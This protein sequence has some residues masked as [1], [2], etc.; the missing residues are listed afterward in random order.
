M[1]K[2]AFGI[3]ISLLLISLVVLFCIILIKLYIEKIKKYNAQIYENEINFQKT[4]NASIVETQEQ[5]LDSIS[6]DLHDDAGQQLTVINFQIENLKF[7]FPNCENNLEPISNS[8]LK[9]SQS[10][11]QI[12]HSLNSNWLE[13]N[14]LIDAI[15]QEVTRIKKSDRISISYKSDNK[16]KNFKNEEQIVL[17]RIF[18]ETINN[19][20][21]HSRATAIEIEVVF[22]PK[23]LLKIQDNGIGFDVDLVSNSN[24]SIGIQNCIKRAE[25]INYIFEIQ[26]I[27][28]EGT[29][30]TLKE[31]N[32]E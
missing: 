14:G 10:L 22:N 8:V 26:S 28:N 31:K 21:K 19:I 30:I 25:V 29:T 32:Y 6:R 3:I 9:L 17:F 20:L 1:T 27:K 18:Q 5:L 13:K 7:D 11:R 16:T 2:I 4:L 15:K 24:H 23:F 12:S